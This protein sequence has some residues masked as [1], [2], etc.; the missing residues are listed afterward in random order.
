MGIQYCNTAEQAADI[1]TK[2]FTNPEDRVR[3]IALIGI[4]PKRDKLHQYGINVPPPKP[5]P[6]KTPK[7]KQETETQ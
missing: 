1:M 5:K 2:G 7:I 3:A 4:Q 6:P